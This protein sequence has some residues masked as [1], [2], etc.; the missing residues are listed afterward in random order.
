MPNC[1]K[2]SEHTFGE[3]VLVLSNLACTIFLRN[4]LTLGVGVRKRTNN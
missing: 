2:Q 1:A 4:L 3:P